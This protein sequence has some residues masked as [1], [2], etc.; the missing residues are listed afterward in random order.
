MGPHGFPMVIP[1]GSKGASRFP[2]FVAL[3]WW[4]PAA[5]RVFNSS[6]PGTYRIFTG[7]HGSSL[8]GHNGHHGQHGDYG[9]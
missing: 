3:H 6:P 9:D 1:W 4:G 2:P 5:A 7:S 8:D